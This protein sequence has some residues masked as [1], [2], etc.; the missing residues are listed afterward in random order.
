MTIVI[1]IAIVTVI[2]LLCAA[3][4]VAA[5]KVMAVRTDE[6]VS[7]LRAL[8][9]GANCGACGYA[10]CDGYAEALAKGA[11]TNKCI[12]GG[13]QVSR[14]ISEI[15]GVPFADV[16]EVVP[17]LMCQNPRTLQVAWENGNRESTC[18]G[19]KLLYGGPWGCTYGCLGYGDCERACP[20]HA[21]YVGACALPHFD[22]EKCISCGICVNHCPQDLIQMIPQTAHLAPWCRNPQ[23]GAKVKNVCE[24]GCL[25]C[26]LCAKACPTGALTMVNNLPHFDYEKCVDCS[27]CIKACPT[28]AI[29][30]LAPL[31]TKTHG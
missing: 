30:G 15:L 11:A 31:P 8:L 9:P 19:A 14:G 29:A 26:T 22:Y 4:L 16:V 3:M 17:H 24:T 6:T 20:Q 25:G 27:A 2:G 23:R 1:A 5:A 13:D 21:I 18:K 12:P 7:N 28:G 10:G